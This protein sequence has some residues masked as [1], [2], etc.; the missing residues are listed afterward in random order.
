MIA[1]FVCLLVMLALHLLPFV[2]GAAAARSGGRALLTGFFSAGL[3]WLGGGLYF[4]LAGGRII[5]GRMAA[6]FGLGSPWLMVVMTALVAAIAAAF[7]GYAGYAVRAL[8]K[9]RAPARD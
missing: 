7:S 6:M 2:Y 5:A 1:V 8:F 4:F 3:L 9:K